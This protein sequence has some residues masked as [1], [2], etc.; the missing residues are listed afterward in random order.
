MSIKE[1]A[2]GDAPFILPAQGGVAA[3]SLVVEGLGLVGGLL[4]FSAALETSLLA[5][6]LHGSPTI[7]RPTSCGPGKAFHGNFRTQHGW[8]WTDPSKTSHI[9]CTGH[10]CGTAMG[11][12]FRSH[13]RGREAFLWA[14][15]L[16]LPSGSEPFF[17]VFCMDRPRSGS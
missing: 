6:F 17:L 3:G 10:T 4:T 12:D 9:R 7:R 15:G 13:C 16:Q 2:T 11:K 8:P 1:P 14:S 5:C